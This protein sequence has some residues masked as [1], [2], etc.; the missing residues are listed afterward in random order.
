MLLYASSEIFKSLKNDY[1]ETLVVY[2]NF[3]YFDGKSISGFP[4]LKSLS[5][6]STSIYDRY[7]NNCIKLDYDLFSHLESLR[8]SK[9][10][11]QSFDYFILPEFC[12]LK[13]LIFEQCSAERKIN[14]ADLFKR[15]KQLEKL[16]IESFN[17]FFNDIPPSN[18]FDGLE[19]LTEL[20][21]CSNELINF[22]PEWFSHKPNL[23]S[24]Y[25]TDNQITVLSIE[26]FSN[27]T[28]LTTLRL[29][30][31]QFNRLEDRVFSHLENL[32]NLSIS[33]NYNIRNLKP[34]V[35][36]GLDKLMSLEMG[37]FND[38]FQL[39]INLFQAL[40]SL[41]RVFLDRRFKEMEHQLFQK[42]GPELNYFYY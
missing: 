30:D 1:V 5:L 36:H 20:N 37:A 29:S 12:N 40:P 26:M 3:D 21:L 18:V 24:L 32:E 14:H 9:F 10:Q 11:F 31:N 13:E 23:K 7:K 33:H 28:N 35:F 6:T 15:F 2:I 41:K 25:L 27:L 34:E 39:D 22:D 19:N 8:L 38:D 42:Y 16:R 17:D 4:N